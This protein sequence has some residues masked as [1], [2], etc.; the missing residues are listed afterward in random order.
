MK[1]WFIGG[2]FKPSRRR[3]DAVKV[4]R[5]SDVP[6]QEVQMEGAAKCQ[7]RWLVSKT[8]GAPNFAMRQFE[9]QPGGH[10]P[11]H[12]HPYEHEIYILEGEGEA[13][14]GDRAHPMKAGDVLLVTPDEVHQFRNTGSTVLKM[15]CLIPNSADNRPVGQRPE[16]SQVAPAPSSA[17]VPLQ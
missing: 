6:L 14:E 8:D 13:W 11:R 15:L 4:Q 12:H 9:L 17:S 10:T 1:S 2:I 3:V 5:S 7:V 16:C